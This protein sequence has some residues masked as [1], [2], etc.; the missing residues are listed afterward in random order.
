MSGKPLSAEESALIQRVAKLRRERFRT[1][2]EMATAL[3]VSFDAY[4]K[5]ESRTPLPVLL[6]PRFAA[7]VGRSIDY[8]LTGRDSSR[9]RGSGEEVPVSLPELED[10]L[11]FALSEEAHQLL[12]KSKP[13]DFAAEY[14]AAILQTLR[15]VRQLR[16]AGRLER[17][18]LAAALRRAVPRRGVEDSARAKQARRPSR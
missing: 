10:I 7:I 12:G 15:E 8:V 5:Y 18:S 6:V 14:A 3:G 13:E 16:E 2:E 17:L 9:R 4:R 1:A 11:A